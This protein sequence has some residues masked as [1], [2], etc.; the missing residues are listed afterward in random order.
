MGSGHNQ[1][2]K[3]VAVLVHRTWANCVNKFTAVSER[4]AYVDLSIR[5]FAIRIVCVYFPHSGY[6]DHHA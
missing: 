2:S 1:N 4:L 6:A 5:M 3:G